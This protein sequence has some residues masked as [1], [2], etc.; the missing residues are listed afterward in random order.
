MP[1]KQKLFEGDEEEDRNLYKTEDQLVQLKVNKHFAARFEHN[2]K[3]EE[4]HRLQAKHPEIAAQVAAKQELADGE[5]EDSSSSEDEDDGYIPEDTERRIFETLLRI[6]RKDP[7]IYDSSV[8]FFPEP[9][10]EEEEE[11]G[12]ADKPKGEKPLYLKDVLAR[13]ALERGPEVSSSSSSSGEEQ[14][15]EEEQEAPAAPS[16]RKPK[17]YDTE[18]EQL[19]RSFLE[20]AKVAEEDGD[21]NEADGFE[22]VLKK[23]SDAIGDAD[24]SSSDEGA[25]QDEEEQDHQQ[26]SKKKKKRKN[27][28][29]GPPLSDLLDAYFAEQRAA[30]DAKDGAASTEANEQFLRSFILNRGWVDHDEAGYVPTYEE[31]VGKDQE[32]GHQPDLID[33]DEDEKYLEETDRFEAAYNF[34]FE[35]PGTAKIAS[36]P[37]VIEGTVRKEDDRRKRQREAKKQRKEAEMAQHAE[38]IKRLKN[39]KKKEIEEKLALIHKV[40]GAKK[41]AQEA[42]EE[43]EEAAAAEADR[44]KAKKKGKKKEPGFKLD[45]SLLENDFDPEAWDRQMAEAFNDEYYAEED[46]EAALAAGEMDDQGGDLFADGEDEE[47]QNRNQTQGAGQQQGHAGGLS[48]EER[49]AG[50]AEMAE[51]LEQYFKL[52][53]EGEAGGQ[54]TRFRYK[55]VPANTF[56]L[57]AED[58]LTRDDKELNQIVGLK[59]LAPYRE[60]QTKQRPNYKALQALRASGGGDDGGSSWPQKKHKGGLNKQQG[61]FTHQAKQKGQKRPRNDARSNSHSEHANGGDSTAPDSEKAQR[62]ASYAKLSLNKPGQLQQQ[63]GGDAGAGGKKH[64]KQRVENQQASAAAAAGGEGGNQAGQSGPKLTKAQK[65]NMKRDQKRKAEKASGQQ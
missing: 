31:I 48:K 10:E 15:E 13:Q 60:D 20:A 6:K 51:L 3:R 23:R 11:E 1:L 14:E 25:G 45:P 42:E 36:H 41:A 26:K 44:K 32:E 21:G 49:A 54:K 16:A 61:E 28:N 29:E 30:K 17:A 65:K 43:E 34:R 52:D 7:A 64:K 24:A 40:A 63:G 59:K 19:R 50:R 62:L 46:E 58:L 4:L 27:E 35:E 56:G 37:R 22:G 12:S 18:Q 47:E 39:L 38:E 53:H 57:S 5:D 33:D 2:K 9:P 8:A 55:Q